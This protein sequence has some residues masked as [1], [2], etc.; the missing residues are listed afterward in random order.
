MVRTVLFYRVQSVCLLHQGLVHGNHYLV[1][2]Y[3]KI[4]LQSLSLGNVFKLGL[5]QRKKITEFEL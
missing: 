1:W 5:I 3:A 4:R 2:K